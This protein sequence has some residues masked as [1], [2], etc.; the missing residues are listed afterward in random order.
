MPLNSF[1][2]L[3]RAVNVGGTGRLPMADLREMCV[4]VGFVGVRTHIARGNV[5]FASMWPE[6]RVTRELEARLL[7][8]ARKPVGVRVRS[9]S[10]M[11]AASA[12]AWHWGDVGSMSTTP[13][14]WR[15]R[16]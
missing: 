10:E 2:A 1:I 12:S 16:S 8:Y 7:D 5:V 11:A 13:R 9:G 15:I 4:G 6:A 3:L 14:A